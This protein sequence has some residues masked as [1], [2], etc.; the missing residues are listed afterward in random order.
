MLN[1]QSDV[2][3]RV[4]AASLIFA[5]LGSA[6]AEDVSVS[7]PFIVR[8]IWSFEKRGMEAKTL[9]HVIASR[10]DYLLE[11]TGFERSDRYHAE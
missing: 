8:S 7:Y 6:R 11:V 4:V 5:W 1:V 9:T 2:V 10:F 3:H